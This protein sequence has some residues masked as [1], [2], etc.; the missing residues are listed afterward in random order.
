MFTPREHGLTD[1]TF[2]TVQTWAALAIWFRALLYLRTI[3]VF[4]WLVTLIAASVVDMATFVVVLVIGVIAF[5]DAILSIESVLVLRGDIELEEVNDDFYSKYAQRFVIAW[6]TQFLSSLGEFDGNIEFY[7]EID[8]LVFL[9]S[10][11]F[12]MIVMFNLLIAIISETFA[13][14]VAEQVTTSYKEK[15]RQI[16]LIQDTLLGL[17]RTKPNPNEM[18]LIAK[19]I[20]SADI[21]EEEADQMEVISDKIEDIRNSIAILAS[22]Q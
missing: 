21:V 14:I 16:T 18:L 9:L 8:W 22:K 7:R 1:T 20:S 4:N 10:T 3:N 12:N 6:Q 13:N 2:W 19:T 5:A 17:Y 11:L 15:A